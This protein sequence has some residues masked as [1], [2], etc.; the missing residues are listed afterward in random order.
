DS[1]ATV[2]LAA[3]APFVRLLEETGT[4]VAARVRLRA[5]KTF[6]RW[7]IALDDLTPDPTLRL[8]HGLVIA[9]HQDFVDELGDPS[10]PLRAGL[11]L[12]SGWSTPVTGRRA[13][14]PPTTPRRT[15]PP[16]DAWSS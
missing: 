2:A 11:K 4:D 13:P 16:T 3:L 9:L 6:A 15:G 12:R 10:A 8:P 1:G 14:S 7:G 5:E